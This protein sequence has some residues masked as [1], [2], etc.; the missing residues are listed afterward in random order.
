[1]NDNET[2]CTLRC[3][4]DGQLFIRSRKLL[5]ECLR[6]PLVGKVVECP[7][8]EVRVG[9]GAQC[10]FVIPD[11]TVSHLHIFLR[12][13]GSTIRV[14]DAKSR[15]GTFIDRVRIRDGYAM[16]TSMIS[17][18]ASEIRVRMLEKEDELAVANRDRFGDLVGSSVVMRR[19]YALIEAAARNN[20]IVLIEGEIGTE[21][22]SAAMAIHLTGT[23]RKKAFVTVDCSAFAPSELECEIFGYSSGSIETTRK[24]RNG[25]WLDA[26]GGTLFL[27]EIGDLPIELQEKLSRTIDKNAVRPLG[28]EFDIPINAR[29]IVGASRDLG[30]EVN[31]NRFSET[32]W[33]RVSNQYIRLPSLR[34]RLDDIPLLVRHFEQDWRDCAHPPPPLPSSVVEALQR[35]AWPGNLRQLRTKVDQLLA[36]GRS[37]GHDADPMLDANRLG[38]I[39]ADTSVPY[40]VGRDQVVD[41]FTR[42]YIFAMLEQT[43]GN[44]VEAATLAGVSGAFIWNLVKASGQ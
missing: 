36:I 26:D 13:E 19:V 3:G 25:G 4:D 5:I 8:P 34:E 44:V 32:L 17:L 7:G 37:V 29:L 40:R 43:N 31:Q 16:P 38:R 30:I 10:H 18:G 22:E 41:T 28:K 24:A 11:R 20:D 33:C 9:S 23:R 21:K 2:S 1:M 14:I 15:N 6:G 35:N 12:I 39:A 27:D 42:S